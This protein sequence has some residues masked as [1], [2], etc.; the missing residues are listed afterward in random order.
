MPD[1][2]ARTV[3][4]SAKSPAAGCVIMVIAV[5]ALV[6]LVGFAVWNLFKLDQ[7]LSKFTE[8]EARPLPTPDLVAEAEAVNVLNSKLEIFR[9]DEGNKR[10]ASLVL[11]PVEINLAIAA[12]EEF[13]ELRETFVVRE[14]VDGKLLIDIA[15][16]MRGSPTKGGYRYLNGRMTATPRLEAG[17]IVLDVE[18][19][20]VGEGEPVPEGFLGQFS[21]YRITEAYKDDETLGPWMKK[22]TTLKLEEGLLRLEAQPDPEPAVTG[23]RRLTRRRLLKIAALGGVILVAFVGLMV[24]AARKSRQMPPSEPPAA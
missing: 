2:E 1:D 12:F 15:F 10:P 13:T 24:Y 9:T 20:E 11:T 4:R 6:F 19:I 18:K 8:K 21:P 23:P 22:L 3:D 5:L 17:E 14:I 16:R 7:E